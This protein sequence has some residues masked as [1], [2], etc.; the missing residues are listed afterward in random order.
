MSNAPFDH[1]LVIERLRAALPALRE[2][3]TAADFKAVQ[4]LQDFPTP[5]AYVLLAEET[6]EPKAAGN[7]TGPARQRVGAM[8][9]V[10]LAVRS[11]RYDQLADA[12]DDLRSILDQVRGALVGWVP[13]LPLGR[14]VQFVTG[15]VLDS[16]D[17]TLLWGEIYSTQHSIGRS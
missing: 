8:F 16:D 9:G 6:G 7:S 13:D 11:Y 10:V 2:V 17:T 15:K 12:A 14:G 4:R 5:A 1:R 3:G